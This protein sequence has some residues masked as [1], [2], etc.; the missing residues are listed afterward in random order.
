MFETWNDVLCCFIV[1][2]T[3]VLSIVALVFSVKCYKTSH[4]TDTFKHSVENMENVMKGG[5]KYMSMKSS[6]NVLSKLSELK[7]GN[8]TAL[9]VLTADWCGYCKKLKSSGELTKVAK[10]YDVVVIDDSHPD[11]KNVMD[12]I[13][14]E[15]FPA[16]GL[17]MDGHVYPYKGPRENITEVIDQFR[18]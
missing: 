13:Q 12:L 6:D 15:G 16:M 8:K 18:K 9:I 14:G 17:F 1:V 5:S 4:F 11:A 7:K 2:V 3:L 10:K